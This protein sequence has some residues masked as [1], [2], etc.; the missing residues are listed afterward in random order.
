MDIATL[1]MILPLPKERLL[2]LTGSA[3]QT[4]AL[5]EIKGKNASR[6]YEKNQSDLFPGLADRNQNYPSIFGQENVVP[7]VHED[8]WM[9]S[10]RSGIEST[11]I[12][13][14]D[15]GT[16]KVQQ[17]SEP[18][19]SEMGSTSQIFIR[20]G[21]VMVK[22]PQDTFAFL[23]PDMKFHPDA[24]T[25]AL[26]KR[27]AEPGYSSLLC[28]SKLS[29]FAFIA[30]PGNQYKEPM[31]FEFFGLGPSDQS[32]K[33]VIPDD[34]VKSTEWTYLDPNEKLLI[35]MIQNINGMSV[36]L[37]GAMPE[38]PKEVM[39]LYRLQD[40]PDDEK[41]SGWKGAWLDNGAGFSIISDQGKI[42]FWNREILESHSR[43]R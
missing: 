43:E 23:G 28:I 13:K 9:E 5:Y 3:V 11:F 35:T 14:F 15:A 4:L 33:A 16:G 30:L 31:A 12:A 17:L 6:L 40:L 8:I 26:N 37:C 42:M 19:Y 18:W 20:P 41:Q 29:D 38:K 2:V 1:E 27:F 32:V 36:V 39:N 34:F 21:G 7:G 25:S 10:T 22:M 24:F